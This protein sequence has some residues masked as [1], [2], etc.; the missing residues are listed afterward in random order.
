LPRNIIR[1]FPLLLSL[2]FFIPG[3]TPANAQGLSTYFGAGS[4]SDTAATQGG[5]PTHQIPDQI[6]NGACENAPTMGGAFGVFGADFMINPHLGVNGEYAFRFKQASYLPLGGLNAR[7][8]FY[9]FNAIYEPISVSK[10]LVPVLEGGVGGAKVSLYFN[11]QFCATTNI[12]AN[13]SGF[14]ANAN[15]FQVHGAF[16]LKIYVTSNVFI[17]PQF[18][19]HWVHNLN[20]DY[21]RDF[22]PRYTISIGYTLGEH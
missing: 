20:Q 17:K 4:A 9:D 6:N 13:Q 7:P 19:A 22:V 14:F 8:A 16:G 15:H 12:C 11:Q 2:L 5:C 1:A 3:D 18:D 10:R 21:G